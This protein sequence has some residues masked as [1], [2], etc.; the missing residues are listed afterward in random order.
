[1]ITVENVSVRFGSKPLFKDVNLKFLDGNCYGLIGANGAG[2]STFLRILSGELEPDSGSV[3]MNKGET[4]FTLKQ[5]HFAFDNETALK[6]VMMGNVELFSIMDEKDALYAKADFSE[7]DGIRAGE[8]EAKFAEMDGWNAESN[9]AILLNG[10]GIAEEL[11]ESLMSELSESIKVKVLLAQALFANP[12]TLLLDEPT[13]G[14][15]VKAIAWLESFLINFEK[16]VIVVSHDRH[17]LDKVCTHIA[18]VDYGRIKIFSGNYEFWRKS[19]ELIAKQLKDSNR[20]K[21][22]KIKELEEFIAR[23]SANASKSKQAT[24]RKKILDKISLD[25]LEPSTRKYPFIDF[26]PERESGKVIATLDCK[27]CIVEG[28][29]ILKDVEITIC[30]GDKIALIGDPIKISAILRCFAHDLDFDGDVTYGQTIKMSYVPN[31]NSFYFQQDKPIVEWLGQYTPEDD[32]KILRGFLGRMLF[33]GDDALKSVTVLSGGEKVRCM[34]SKSMIE[35]PNLLF[36][37]DPTN[38]LDLESITSLNDGL[39]AYTGE[40]MFISHDHQFIQTIANRIIE[41]T[42]NG[43]IDR[44]MSYDDY[45]YSQY[46]IEN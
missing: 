8:L 18:D 38:H 9:A 21:E 43:I 4:L 44:M 2:K 28:K 6:T 31:D 36:M 42:D 7:E 16:T 30:K 19:S 39:I 45:L 20:K 23:F 14:L 13:N 41:V 17:F 24:S 46:G 12:D 34:L 26:K 29:E 5:D 35:G 3:S 27:S 37:D 25:E 15:D 22:D 11:H 40:L 32:P 1:M 33:S 10:L